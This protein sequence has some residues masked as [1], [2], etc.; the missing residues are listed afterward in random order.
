MVLNNNE[1]GTV[2]GLPS[3]CSLLP[4]TQHCFLT[5][6]SN[7]GTQGE[8]FAQV[9]MVWMIQDSNTVCDYTVSEVKAMCM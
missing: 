7:R 5:T 3:H 8:V 1:S 2:L 9:L 4:A 6:S